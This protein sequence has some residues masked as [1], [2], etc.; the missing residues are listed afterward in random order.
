LFPFASVNPAVYRA[1]CPS[2][3]RMAALAAQGNWTLQL[4][5][6]TA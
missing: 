5:T 4:P 2:V 6:L 3:Y 1:G